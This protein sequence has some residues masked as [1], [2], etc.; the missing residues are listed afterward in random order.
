MKEVYNQ[1]GI[2]KNNISH[3]SRNRA[4][5]KRW[6]WELYL[7]IYNTFKNS[8]RYSV[9]TSASELEEY[10]KVILLVLSS[11]LNSDSVGLNGELCDVDDESLTV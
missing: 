6:I 3:F 7:F 5:P 4:V 1:Q 10:V 9:R 2:I 11:G 8:A